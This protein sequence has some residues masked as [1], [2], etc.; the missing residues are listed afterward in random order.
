M[1]DEYAL[2]GFH[3]ASMSP[4]LIGQVSLGEGLI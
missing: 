4:P 3:E 2:G 1:V